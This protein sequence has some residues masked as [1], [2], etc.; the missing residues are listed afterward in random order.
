MFLSGFWTGLCGDRASQDLLCAAMAAVAAATG[1]VGRK[2][3]AGALSEGAGNTG[4]SAA[5][6]RRAQWVDFN[7][8]DGS[9]IWHDVDDDDDD[10][11]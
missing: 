4:E 7:D 9:A 5:E 6:V 8:A 2:R 3:P 11:T 10:R 1:T